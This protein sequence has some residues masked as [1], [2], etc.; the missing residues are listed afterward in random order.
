MAL[1]E[2]I[3]FIQVNKMV[4]EKFLT[5][6]FDA[7]FDKEMFTKVAKTSLNSKLIGVYN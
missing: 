5:F 3:A 1:K 7:S 6:K 2:S 4:K